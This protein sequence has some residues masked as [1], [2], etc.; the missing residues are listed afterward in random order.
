MALVTPCRS[1]E[2]WRDL[3]YLD[4]GVLPRLIAFVASHAKIGQRNR[5]KTE[6]VHCVTNLDNSDP[7]WRP[8]DTCNLATFTT[9]LNGNTTLGVAVGLLRCVADQLQ[10]EADVIRAMHERVRFCQDLQIEFALPLHVVS[11]RRH[12]CSVL[13]VSTGSS[14]EAA[15]PLPGPHLLGSDSSTSLSLDCPW[16]ARTSSSFGSS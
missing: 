11:T 13:A 8:A 9:A 16:G 1:A 7:E 5:Q 14:V 15:S 10:A 6:V 3:W 12:R 2:V 4:D